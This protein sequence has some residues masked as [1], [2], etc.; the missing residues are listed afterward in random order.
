VKLT[1]HLKIFAAIQPES[2]GPHT[3]PLDGLMCYGRS[4]WPMSEFWVPSPHR[5]KDGQRFF[6]KQAASAAHIYGKSIVCA[7]GFT[8][9]FD[10]PEPRTLNPLFLDL[11]DLSMLAE[12]RLNGKNLGVV[13]CPPWRVEITETVKATGNVLEVDVVNGWWNQLAGDPKK[14]HTKTNIRLNPNARPQASGLFGPAQI[15][16]ARHP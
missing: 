13:W 10:M 6:V 16:E 5:P 2:A 14:E 12:V 7:E 8:S 3:A 9:I 15:L 1:S 11:G 4:A